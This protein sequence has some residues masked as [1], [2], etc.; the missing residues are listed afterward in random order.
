ML[1]FFLQIGESRSWRWNNNDIYDVT[2]AAGEPE[3]SEVGPLTYEFSLIPHYEIFWSWVTQ[4]DVDRQTLWIYVFWCLFLLF[5]SCV[6][7]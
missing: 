1:S 5:S 3:K 4:A 7:C 6:Y 2:Q